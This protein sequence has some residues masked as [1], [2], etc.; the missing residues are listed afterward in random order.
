MCIVSHAR[1]DCTSWFATTITCDLRI[2]RPTR[3]LLRQRDRAAEYWVPMDC[4]TRWEKPCCV[5]LISLSIVKRRQ[6]KVDVLPQGLE[7]RISCSV[8]RRLIHWATGATVM[9]NG[10]AIVQN[11]KQNVKPMTLRRKVLR[12][13]ASRGSGDPAAIRMPNTNLSTCSAASPQHRP[14]RRRTE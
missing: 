8:G 6:Q 13:Q 9:N 2:M 11:V 5:C 10:S 12:P 14:R 1:L 7:P 4:R 3:C